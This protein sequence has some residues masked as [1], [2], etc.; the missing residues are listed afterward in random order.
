LIDVGILSDVYS[1]PEERTS[2]L[3]LRLGQRQ[4]ENLR[5][6]SGEPTSRPS[7]DDQELSK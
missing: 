4:A 1:K 3:V 6:R 7:S 5:A 2:P